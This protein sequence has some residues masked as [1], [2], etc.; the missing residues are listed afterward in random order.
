LREVEVDESWVIFRDVGGDRC[1][2]VFAAI[3]EIKEMERGKDKS[4]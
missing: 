2:V 3:E 4:V 1:K